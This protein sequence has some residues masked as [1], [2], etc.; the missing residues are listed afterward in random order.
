SLPSP[1]A[2]HESGQDLSV[3]EVVLAL[4]PRIKETAKPNCGFFPLP[5]FRFNHFF[6]GFYS[7][8]GGQVPGQ[9]NE[10]DEARGGVVIGGWVPG[11]GRVIAT[12]T[13]S[14]QGPLEGSGTLTEET[15]LELRWRE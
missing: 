4:D 6:A 15:T 14:R 12:R 1:V 9:T 5:A 8:H 7:M 10:M 13:Y 11:M 3:T 2:A